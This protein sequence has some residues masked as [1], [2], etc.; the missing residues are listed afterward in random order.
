VRTLDKF[1]LG[2]VGAIALAIA[3]SNAL[4]DLGTRDLRASLDLRG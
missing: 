1:T 4:R 2:L 3:F